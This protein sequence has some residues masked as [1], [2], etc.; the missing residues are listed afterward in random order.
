MT[1][2]LGWII[3]GLVGLIAAMV[4]WPRQG[5]VGRWR[6]A[7]RL[8][9]RVLRE[10]ALKHM[11][12]AEVNGQA[13]TLNSVAGALQI[14]RDRAARVLSEMES[15]GLISHRDGS[16]RM[17]KAGR[18]LAL[19]IIRAHRL[20]ESYLAEQTGV[21]EAEWH[22]RAERQEHLLSPE[23]AAALAAQLGHPAFDPHGDAI[24]PV[25]GELG[26]ES[27]QSL[28]AAP[29]LAPV[30]IVH[31][32][33]EPEVIYAQLCAQGLRS[34]M[35]VCVLEKSPEGIRFWADGGE[36]V[37]APILANNISVAPV[38]GLQASDLFEEHYLSLLKP[39]ERATVL[40][41]SPC[42]RGSERRRLLDLGFV[43]GTPVEIEMVSPAGDPT[44]YRVRDTLVALRR[45][46]AGLIRI[47]K[48][49]ALAA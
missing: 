32:E 14:K 29:V 33:D 8:A 46:Q 17:S 23:A 38:P 6:E 22:H 24:P 44:A 11:L 10:D 25:G 9:A 39:G 37:L 36:H 13:P 45:E 28:N 18:E 16:L 34:G 42:C 4:F 15:G 43:A 1:G 40:G 35:R 21:S 47:S 49:A 7:R 2:M 27:G 30:R 19:H 20:W 31:I 48:E 5:L 41:L 26:A 3:I 12:K